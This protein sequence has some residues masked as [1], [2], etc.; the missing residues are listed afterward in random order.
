MSTFLLRSGVEGLLRGQGDRHS[1]VGGPTSGLL[2]HGATAWSEGE[3]WYALLSWVGGRMGLVTVCDK[4]AWVGDGCWQGLATS[5]TVLALVLAIVG[6]LWGCVGA[7]DGYS[8]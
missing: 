6:T 7:D 5:G 2:G 8:L 1:V 3:G 4:W